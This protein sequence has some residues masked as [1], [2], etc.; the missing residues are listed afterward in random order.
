VIISNAFLSYFARML[1]LLVKVNNS[2]ELLV[3]SD[4]IS[5]FVSG[6]KVTLI[7]NIR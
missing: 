5:Y 6:S 7:M 4:I 1:D 2:G 3:S